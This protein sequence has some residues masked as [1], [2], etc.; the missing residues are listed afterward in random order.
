MGVVVYLSLLLYMFRRL[1]PPQYSELLPLQSIL[2]PEVAGRALLEIVLPQS[3][4]VVRKISS[5]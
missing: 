2:Q 5:D 4:D 1:P 3:A